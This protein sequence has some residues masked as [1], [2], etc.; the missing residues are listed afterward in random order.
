PLPGRGDP[1]SP[2]SARDKELA[3]GAAEVAQAFSV[4]CGATMLADPCPIMMFG[5]RALLAH[6]DA[7]CTDDAAYQAFR[8][9]VRSAAWQRDFLSRPLAERVATARALRARSESEKAGKA[10]YLMD[11]N[12]QAVEHAMRIASARLLVHGHTHRPASH[13]LVID[14]E[15]AQRWVLPDWDAVARRGGMLLATSDGLQRLGAWD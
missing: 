14:G 6:G 10:G 1:D 11:V 2:R 3:G 7:L 5:T 8:A 12:P 4:R 15:P 9:Q 13:R